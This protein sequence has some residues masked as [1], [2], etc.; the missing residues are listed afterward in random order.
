MG[1]GFSGFSAQGSNQIVN[2]STHETFRSNF[3]RSWLLPYLAIILIVY[4]PAMLCNI[5]TG[6]LK[7]PTKI[8][9]GDSCRDFVVAH[10]VDSCAA[11]C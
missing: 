11:V 1:L 7:A 6:T 3:W 8:P 10:T 9:C 5:L 4:V 2:A